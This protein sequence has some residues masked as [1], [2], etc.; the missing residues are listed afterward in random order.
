MRRW[1]CSRKRRNG[2]LWRAL[3]G[4]T[5]DERV[6]LAESGFRPTRYADL[7]AMTLVGLV[8]RLVDRRPGQP[9]RARARLDTGIHV[10]DAELL[11][12]RAHHLHQ[13][14]R[15]A[16]G[17]H[18]ARQLARRQGA[19]LFELRAAIHD[20]E[21]RGQPARAALIDTVR[22]LPADNVLPEL[23]QPARYWFHPDR[24]AGSHP[25]RRHGLRR[26]ETVV[27]EGFNR[28]RERRV[29]CFRANNGTNGPHGRQARRRAAAEIAA[30]RR[31][32]VPASEEMK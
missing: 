25:G 27:P 22:L 12:V 20:F 21:S 7:T 6:A 30:Q 4:M 11:R 1:C 9:H 3:A 29:L 14:R 5:L 17:F 10:Y 16:A 31:A 32:S 23:A 18:T 15:R 28:P 13:P 8:G 2:K 19:P 24:R 26:I